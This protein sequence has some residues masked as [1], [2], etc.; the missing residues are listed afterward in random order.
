M[1]AIM[2]RLRNNC[3]VCEACMHSV[4][5]TFMRIHKFGSCCCFCCLR[6]MLLTLR[7]W[8]RAYLILEDFMFVDIVVGY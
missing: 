7:L 5:G 3:R 6:R 4:V 1:D 2:S 8:S